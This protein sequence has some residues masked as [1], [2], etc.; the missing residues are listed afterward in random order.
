MDHLHK[1]R[2][3]ETML[4][5]NRLHTKINVYNPQ[6]KQKLGTRMIPSPIVMSQKL[7]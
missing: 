2:V 1:T 5:R 7:D 4:G 6:P 3:Q